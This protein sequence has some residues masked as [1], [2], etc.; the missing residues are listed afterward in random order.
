MAQSVLRS[1]PFEAVPKPFLSGFFYQATLL[2]VDP[3]GG[4]EQFKTYFR[5]T[6]T[7]RFFEK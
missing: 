7:E 2:V 5:K 4:L 3:P 1:W 6:H